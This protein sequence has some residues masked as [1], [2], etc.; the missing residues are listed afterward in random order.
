MDMTLHH[1]FDSLTVL[2]SVEQL[3]SRGH[4]IRN[5]NSTTWRGMTSS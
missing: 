4:P 2:H 5:R 3:A 1:T